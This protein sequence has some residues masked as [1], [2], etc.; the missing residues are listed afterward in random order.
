MSSK[1]ILPDSSALNGLR[2]LAIVYVMVSLV[3]YKHE[4]S[5][6]WALPSWEELCLHLSLI[7]N[8]HMEFFRIHFINPN[9]CG[10]DK[11]LGPFWTKKSSYKISV[12]L[13][14]KK[15]TLSCNDILHY[16]LN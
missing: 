1:A 4:T 11:K 5:R 16:W 6:D 12:H 3:R 2:G 8:D 14:D 15:L 9:K 13:V 10:A 7:N